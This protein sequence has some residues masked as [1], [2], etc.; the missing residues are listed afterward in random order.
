[1]ASSTWAGLTLCIE[2]VD[3][4]LLISMSS[5]LSV[6]LMTRWGPEYG[7][8]SGVRTVSSLSITCEQESKVCGT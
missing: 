4:L 5:V 2:T 7:G 3:R 6:R 1:M 8:C